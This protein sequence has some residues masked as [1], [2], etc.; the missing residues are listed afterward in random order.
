M[1][2]SRRSVFTAAPPILEE[3][4][5]GAQRDR[6][7]GMRRGHE[8]ARLVVALAERALV[9]LVVAVLEPAH[10][11]PPD[12]VLEGQRGG[13]ERELAPEA[14]ARAVGVLEVFLAQRGA[15]LGRPVVGRPEP[16]APPRG[17]GILA[18]VERDQR[19]LTIFLAS[20]DLAGDC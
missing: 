2:T 19:G 7:H 9:R 8:R 3:R 17:V 13:P 10:E 4:V 5:V 20:G 18:R 14:R 12:L 16:P 6:V 1:G 15:E 11:A